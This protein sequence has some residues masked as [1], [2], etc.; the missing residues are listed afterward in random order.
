MNGFAIC[1]FNVEII[2][3]KHKK[4]LKIKM[5][6][7][8]EVLGRLCGCGKNRHWY[9]IEC[10]MMLWNQSCCLREELAVPDGLKQ[11]VLIW[12]LVSIH[13][14]QYF[15]ING[16]GRSTEM[17]VS[18]VKSMKELSHEEIKHFLGF[19]R[20]KLRLNYFIFLNLTWTWQP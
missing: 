1:L 3:S 20:V 11:N 17:D 19:G 4:L 6:R 18:H 2:T 13:F 16:H 14:S 5:G 8:G 9:T 12:S 15:N 7:A 10:G